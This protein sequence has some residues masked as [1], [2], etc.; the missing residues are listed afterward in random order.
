MYNL[1]SRA[2]TGKEQNLHGGRGSVAHGILM[3]QFESGSKDEKARVN[4]YSTSRLSC[5]YTNVTYYLIAMFPIC[6]LNLLLKAGITKSRENLLF[7]N[8]CSISIDILK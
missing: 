7:R 8:A 2:H 5:G 4:A 6:I 1:K 3:W